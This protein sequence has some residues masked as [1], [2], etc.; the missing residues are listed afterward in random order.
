[1]EWVESCLGEEVSRDTEVYIDMFLTIR[2]TCRFVYSSL[3]RGNV[4]SKTMSC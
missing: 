2:S 4:F 1:M 3:W